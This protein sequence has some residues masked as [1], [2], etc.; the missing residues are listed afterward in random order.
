M[1]SSAGCRNKTC[2]V[3][4]LT[5][6]VQFLQ[7]K[8]SETDPLLNLA[9]VT[10]GS[11][12]TSGF[13]FACKMFWTKR[14]LHSFCFVLFFNSDILQ[15]FTTLTRG[16]YAGIIKSNQELGMCLDADQKAGISLASFTVTESAC[17]SSHGGK[18][19][20]KQCFHPPDVQ[21]LHDFPANVSD[22]QERGTTGA[23]AILYKV[24]VCVCV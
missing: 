21:K 13:W 2:W 5:S 18:Q 20:L 23:K 14:K 17:K 11:S 6:Q 12:G 22:L 19:R 9:S 16:G 10:K 15:L 8:L 24:C 1:S 3:I 7:Q 4:C